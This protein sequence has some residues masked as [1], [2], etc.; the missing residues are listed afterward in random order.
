MILA[1]FAL[2]G[3]LALLLMALP[4]ALI[5]SVDSAK[6]LVQTLIMM[7]FEIPVARPMLIGIT[8]SRLEVVAAILAN[9]LAFKAT[10]EMP[11]PGR[12]LL[13]LIADVF[14]QEK[15]HALSVARARDAS[16]HDMMTQR[17]LQP[18]PLNCSW[19]LIF[20]I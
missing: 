19:N 20:V 8:A 16:L 18:Q 3:R 13:T 1:M 6:K 17:L 9:L 15:R 14:L 10:R 5:A 4:L 12:N 2:L 7:V 11:V